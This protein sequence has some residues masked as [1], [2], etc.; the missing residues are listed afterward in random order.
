ML[1]AAWVSPT[2]KKPGFLEFS[3]A[4]PITTL[5]TVVYPTTVDGVAKRLPK[6]SRR[7]IHPSGVA[8]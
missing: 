6:T 7:L 3:L 1:T 5:A 4:T 8:L 2:Q